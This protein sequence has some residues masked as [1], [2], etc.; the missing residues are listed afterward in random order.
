M[1]V[2]KYQL[3]SS[4]EN[5]GVILSCLMQKHSTLS[6]LD[7]HSWTLRNLLERPKATSN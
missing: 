5:L 6:L 2:L 3:L 1:K 7:N 4:V